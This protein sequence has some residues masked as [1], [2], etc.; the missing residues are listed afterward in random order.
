L[1]KLTKTWL[2]LES[3]LGM[4]KSRLAALAVNT[5]L[6][7]KISIHEY[8]HATVVLRAEGGKPNSITSPVGSKIPLAAAGSAGIILLSE[9]P[10]EKRRQALKAVDPRAREELLAAAASAEKEGLARTYGTLQ[11]SI[12]AVSKPVP[13]GVPAAVSLVGWPEDFRD[14]KASRVEKI[15]RQ[16]DL[17]PGGC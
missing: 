15:L 12:F 4:I 9:L 14:G 11:P 7:A 1:A 17:A 2:A 13:L 10:A 8:G 16:Y 3:R 6:S 5:G